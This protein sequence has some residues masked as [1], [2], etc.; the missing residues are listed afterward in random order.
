PPPQGGTSTL[1][2]VSACALVPKTEGIQGS[3]RTRSGGTVFA[4]S[5]RLLTL[6]LA[7]RRGRFGSARVRPLKRSLPGSGGTT[8]RDALDSNFAGGMPAGREAGTGRSKA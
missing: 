7:R 8:N 1:N 3:L 5:H 4:F 6:P 2:P